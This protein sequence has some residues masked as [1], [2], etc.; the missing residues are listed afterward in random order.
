M[1]CQGCHDYTSWPSICRIFLNQ[2]D[3]QVYFKGFLVATNVEVCKTIHLHLC[4]LEQ[5]HHAIK[6]MVC[7]THS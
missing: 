7:Y 6:H 1:L 2:Q 3:F 5:K 4:V